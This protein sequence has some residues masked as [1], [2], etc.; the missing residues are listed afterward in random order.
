MENLCQNIAPL[1]FREHAMNIILL[2]RELRQTMDDMF[3][4]YGMSSSRWLALAILE[5]SGKPLSQKEL[6]LR[7]DIEGAS[8]VRIVDC[9]E[10]DG[11]VKRKTSPHD[12]RIKLVSMLPKAKE[13]A[14]IFAKR[15]LELNTALYT[16]I[17]KERIQQSIAFLDQLRQSLQSFAEDLP[18]A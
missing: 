14:D 2:A 7:M 4:P 12:R 10:R 13:F 1:I 17:S 8:L 9:L 3:K 6:A 11:W 5:D 15:V 18:P 16:G